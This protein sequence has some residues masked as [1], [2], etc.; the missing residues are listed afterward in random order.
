MSICKKWLTRDGWIVE[1]V[2]HRWLM[3]GFQAADAG[4]T[5]DTADSM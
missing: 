2:Y 5:G 3:P 1:G 4:G